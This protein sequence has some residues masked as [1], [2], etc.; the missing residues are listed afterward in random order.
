MICLESAMSVHEYSPAEVKR[1]ITGSG[2]APKPQLQRMLERLIP[3]PPDR[4]G[5]DEA[6]ALAIAY[7]HLTRPP[8]PA[9]AGLKYSA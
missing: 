5:D 7:C 9:R 1:A 2:S 3:N 6:D 8:I 4:P